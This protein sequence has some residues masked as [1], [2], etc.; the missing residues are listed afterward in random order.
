MKFRGITLITFGYFDETF[1]RLVSKT[2]QSETGMNLSLMS[3]HLDLSEFFDSAR[4]QYNADKLLKAVDLRYGRDT[5]KTVGLFKVDLFIPILTYVFGQAYLRG[6]TGI[7]SVYRL[8]NE[9][10][11]INPDNALIPQR[12]SK[13][14]IH[15]LGHGFGLVHCHM[16][17]CIMRSSTYLEDIDQK[18]QSFCES[19]REAVR[20]YLQGD[21]QQPA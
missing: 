3:G 10:Y 12:F 8:N 6:R 1:I 13:E 14:I 16:P 21:Q 7:V 4:R 11:G 18:S 5:S 20:S 9:I 2:V 15:E 19:C 17:D